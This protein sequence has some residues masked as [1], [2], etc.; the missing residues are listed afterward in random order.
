MESK[1]EKE[2]VARKGMGWC[3]LKKGCFLAPQIDA[4]GNR[5]SNR[6]ALR[7]TGNKE[8]DGHISH[9]NGRKSASSWLRE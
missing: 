5:D 9:E 1:G 7:S 8:I 6:I 2:R 4:F 3:V